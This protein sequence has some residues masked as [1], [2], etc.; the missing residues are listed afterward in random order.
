MFFN[1]SK[2]ILMVTKG[3]DYGQSLLYLSPLHLSFIYIYEPILHMSIKKYPKS[4]ADL[5][6]F[7]LIQLNNL[8]FHILILTHIRN[9]T[10]YTAAGL[11]IG[12]STD[13]QVPSPT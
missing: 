8:V 9:K 10:N 5:G 12:N 1:L 13:I 11:S 4:K 7:F 6:Y 3:R 2:I